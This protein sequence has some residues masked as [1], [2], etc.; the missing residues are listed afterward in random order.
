MM[1]ILK[2]IY[3]IVR[4]VASVLTNARPRLAL[5]LW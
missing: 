1:A 3:S 5:L 4:G 2:P